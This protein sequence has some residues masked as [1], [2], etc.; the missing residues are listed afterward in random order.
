M[1]DLYYLLKQCRSLIGWR[2]LGIATNKTVSS[3]AIFSATYKSVKPVALN[4][5]EGFRRECHINTLGMK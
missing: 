3:C 1:F 2:L 4:W 5:D